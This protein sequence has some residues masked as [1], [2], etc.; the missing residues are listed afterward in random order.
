MEPE[1]AVA[2]DKA[3]GPDAVAAAERAVV[4]G[5]DRA[6]PDVEITSKTDSRVF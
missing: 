4:V 5:R 2:A 1:A 6:A 3:N